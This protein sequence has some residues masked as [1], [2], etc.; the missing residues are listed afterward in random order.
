LTSSEKVVKKGKKTKKGKKGKKKKVI[1]NVG[2]YF[3][4]KQG[5][6]NKNLITVAEVEEDEILPLSDNEEKYRLPNDDDL[7]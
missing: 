2:N 5:L 4:E 6:A 3:A 7:D 1:S